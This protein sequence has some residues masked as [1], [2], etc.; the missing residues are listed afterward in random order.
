MEFSEFLNLCLWFCRGGLEVCVAVTE[1]FLRGFQKGW[2]EGKCPMEPGCAG[3]ESIR[4]QHRLDFLPD[5]KATGSIRT[6]SQ[7]YS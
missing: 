7:Y 4:K 5:H 3:L 2:L 6:G 1:E